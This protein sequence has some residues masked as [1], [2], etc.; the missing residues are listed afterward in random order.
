MWCHRLDHFARFNS[1]GSMSRCGHM[2][3]P[4]R[5]ASLTE[6]ENSSW[7]AGVK[8]KFQNDQWPNECINCQETENLNQT[9]IRLNANKLHETRTR[10]DYLQ[11]AG[12]LDNVCN[13]ACQM[14][15]AQ[16]STKI[17]SL[18]GANYI[19]I[20]NEN[21]FW[22]LPL[23]RIEHLDI[24]GGEPSASK[25]YKKILANLPKNLKT[26]RVNTNCSLLIP[27]LE[28]IQKSGVDVTVTVSFDGIGPVH[29]Y[30]RWPIVW[31]KF[32]NNLMVY[33][34]YHLAG[35]NLWTTIN[36]L[37]INDM[38]NIFSFVDQHQF[39]HSYAFLKFPLPLNV[40]FKNRLTLAAKEKYTT[41]PD[42]R[43]Q[44]MSEFLAVEEN[45]QIELETFVAKQ[46]QLRSINIVDFIKT[47]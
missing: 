32:V 13:S 2:I 26:L 47:D 46:D 25:N 24:N 28:D 5:F 27:E 17:G 22:N 8:E 45:N 36:A 10:D 43:L 1:D 44:R 20:N 18:S 34:R 38:E 42:T 41:H 15:S 39:D 29:D 35:L 11:I 31:D 30:I 7:L 16:L 12:V 4:P 23:D 6:M 40:K 19:R 14:C 21:S 33:Q 37:N 3:Q 9:S